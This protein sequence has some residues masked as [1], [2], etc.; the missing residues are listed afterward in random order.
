MTEDGKEGKSQMIATCGF[1]RQFSREEVVTIADNVDTFGVDM[2]TRI[3]K[4]KRSS[5]KQEVLGQI[6]AHQ[7][8]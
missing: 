6:L 7:E 2:R 1:L 4:F 8:E 3:K 5:K